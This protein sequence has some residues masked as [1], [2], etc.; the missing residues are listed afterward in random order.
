MLNNEDSLCFLVLNNRYWLVRVDV[1][2]RKWSVQQGLD[3]LRLRN[4]CHL[5]NYTPF[6]KVIKADDMLLLRITN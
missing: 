5:I 2:Q 3:A 4:Q 6:S 1:A